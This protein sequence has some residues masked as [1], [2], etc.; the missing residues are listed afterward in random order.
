[1]V[2]DDEKDKESTEAED[3]ECHICNCRHDKRNA[4]LQMTRPL[5]KLAS[6]LSEDDPEIAIKGLLQRIQEQQENTLKIMTHLERTY[7]QNNDEGKAD[8]VSDKADNL[9]EQINQEITPACLLV[10][11]LTKIAKVKSH[12]SSVTDSKK[13]A[14]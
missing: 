13:L 9:V 10:A 5:N 7:R 1:M 11:S 6:A 14:C 2:Y 8:K 12:A 3:Q 4:K